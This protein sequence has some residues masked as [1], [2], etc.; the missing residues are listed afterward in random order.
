MGL[1][2]KRYGPFSTM[3]AVGRLVGTLEPA[4]VIVTM[5]HANNV[6][7]T[8]NTIAP[9][10][11]AGRPA[12]MNRK[13]ASQ[14]S[15]SPAMTAD[16]HA[17]GGRTTTR[18]VSAVASMAAPR[19]RRSCLCQFAGDR[20]TAAKTDPARSSAALACLTLTRP[21]GPHDRADPR[22]TAHRAQ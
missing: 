4:L 19:K 16:P 17:S 18:A 21:P 20:Q 14:S 15:A 10:Q 9:N 22:S 2:V 13:G 3:V 8:P 12:G 1:R 7:A 6:N 5:A 11:R